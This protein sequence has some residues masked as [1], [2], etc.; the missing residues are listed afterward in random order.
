[1][2]QV[3]ESP[4]LYINLSKHLSNLDI[5]AILLLRLLL[6][7]MARLQG[8]TA[9]GPKPSSTCP[10]W[11]NSPGLTLYN[12]TCNCHTGVGGLLGDNAFDRC[13]LAGEKTSILTTI[14]IP[15]S[16]D[17]LYSKI[18]QFDDGAQNRHNL[19]K[20]ILN[21]RSKPS[22]GNN[23]AN[24]VVEMIE[25]QM[26]K[27]SQQSPLK[28]YDRM[29]HMYHCMLGT[30]VRGYHTITSPKFRR[31]VKSFHLTWCRD[32]AYL[33]YSIADLFDYLCGECNGCNWFQCKEEFWADAKRVC[34]EGDCCTC[35]E[36]EHDEKNDENE[37]SGDEDRNEGSDGEDN[38]ECCCAC[39]CDCTCECFCEHECWRNDED[40]QLE[41]RMGCRGEDPDY[42]EKLW[43]YLRSDDCPGEH[44]VEG[45]DDEHA[46][47]HLKNT[48]T[49]VE[50][51]MKLVHQI[52]T[53]RFGL[54]LYIAYSRVGVSK[55]DAKLSQIIPLAFLYDPQIGRF[56]TIDTPPDVQLLG[57]EA[58]YYVNAA[59]LVPEPKPETTNER[60][61]RLHQEAFTKLEHAMKVL[62][63]KPKVHPMQIQPNEFSTASTKSELEYDRRDWVKKCK[64]LAFP[65]WVTLRSTEHAS[66]E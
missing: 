33:G 54:R 24:E 27:P 20:T 25:K 15:V 64:E 35:S 12:L 58:I 22:N 47:V 53:R 4:E 60:D 30:C 11:A 59:S 16:I 1:M 23:P 18:H 5:L 48:K 26:Y 61:S 45:S 13:V 21:L 42:I 46:E 65:K 36:K 3:H 50:K 39:Q 43:E 38:D 6:P 66:A 29:H 31:M 32:P 41:L 8:N 52:L 10:H 55:D 2:K 57:S 37:D 49:K 17:L 40:P 51:N 44:Q 14:A 62:D 56:K 19:L 63:L 9:R 34:C 7:K 28:L